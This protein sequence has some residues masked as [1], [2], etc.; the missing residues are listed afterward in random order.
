M[1]DFRE[2]LEEGGYRLTSVPNM[3][4]LI[5][6]VRKEE[7]EMI[8]GEI[9]GHNVSVIFDGTTRLGE[10]L[11]IVVRF[12][13]ADWEIKQRLVRLQLIAKSLKGDEIGSRNH[14]GSCTTIQCAKQQSLCSNEG[15]SLG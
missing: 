3:R 6:F 1:D 2:L 15:W 13:T 8:K 4:Q 9:S 11:A 12:I 7:E 5:P 10:A 14:H